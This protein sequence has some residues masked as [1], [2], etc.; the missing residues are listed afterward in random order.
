MR[1]IL[2]LRRIAS[3]SILA[4]LLAF[5]GQSANAGE[6]R[7][8]TRPHYKTI[9]IYETIRKPCEHTVI[10]YNHCGKPYTVTV[11][12]WKTVQVPVIKRVLVV[13]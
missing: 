8:R 11:T 6:S 12:T 10:R 9:A 1:S 7:H 3:L 13:Y 2:S 5:S 4:G